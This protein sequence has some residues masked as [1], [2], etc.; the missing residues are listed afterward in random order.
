MPALFKILFFLTFSINA[1]SQNFSL[2][3][4]GSNDYVS[5]ADHN[6]LDLID[7]YTL[8]AWVKA[9]SFS[10]LGGIISK[11]QTNA[12][13]GYTLRLTDVSP[14]DGVGFDGK[15]TSLGQLNL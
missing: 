15:Y 5:I 7:N 1:Q 6:E 2:S 9:E 4:D 10:W 13:N 14:Y 12:A 3:F 11:Y 8:E